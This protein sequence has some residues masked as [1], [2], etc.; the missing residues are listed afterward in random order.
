[1][2]Q[3]GE[4]FHVW[5]WFGVWQGHTIMVKFGACG[6]CTRVVCTRQSS[7]HDNQLACNMLR[8]EHV[9]LVHV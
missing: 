9:V 2:M 7:E 5:F 3:K 8:R 6:T 4:S 1:M